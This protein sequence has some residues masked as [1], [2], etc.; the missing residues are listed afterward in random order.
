MPS[1]YCYP[2]KINRRS[3]RSNPF[4]LY[5]MNQKKN[6][7][8]EN[9]PLWTRKNSILVLHRKLFSAFKGRDG[10]FSR[11]YFAILLK[12]AYH[13]VTSGQKLMPGRFD[14]SRRR[15]E[16]IVVLYP[17]P[18]KINKYSFR[19]QGVQRVKIIYVTYVGSSFFFSWMEMFRR[20]RRWPRVKNSSCTYD[21]QRNV[22]MFGMHAD[23]FAFTK[24][25]YSININIG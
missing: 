9:L 11:W 22:R 1:L 24:N 6:S 19:T 16:E 21:I 5:F 20:Q 8:C 4:S 7:R 2:S 13:F 14:T 3:R 25:I 12:C 23:I 15:R 10:Y 18:N 17:A